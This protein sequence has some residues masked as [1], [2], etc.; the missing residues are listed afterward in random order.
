[1]RASFSLPSAVAAAFQNLNVLTSRGG[2]L[3]CSVRCLV[4]EPGCVSG[5]K[6]KHS[7]KLLPPLLL[8]DR[9]QQ[10][11]SQEHQAATSFL[12]APSHLASVRLS[13]L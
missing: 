9:T 4:T 3:M 2:E 13:L 10:P 12:P 8:E 7:D 11:G 1:M 5:C 6:W